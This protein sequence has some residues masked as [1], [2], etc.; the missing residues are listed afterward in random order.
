[1]YIYKKAC[2]H[3]YT[4]TYLLVLREN[5]AILSLGFLVYRLDLQKRWMS[6]TSTGLWRGYRQQ[7]APDHGLELQETLLVWQPLPFGISEM[8]A[9]RFPNAT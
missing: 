5:L 9:C 7:I 2:E 8:V 3:V 4:M 6:M 1:M